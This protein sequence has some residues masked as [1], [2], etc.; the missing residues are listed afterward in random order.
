MWD[1][2]MGAKSA[3]TPTCKISS[4]KKKKKEKKKRKSRNMEIDSYSKPYCQATCWY[5]QHALWKGKNQQQA[6][7]WT[8]SF[9]IYVFSNFIFLSYLYGASAQQA[10]SPD[11]ILPASLW[12]PSGRI[13]LHLPL[14]LQPALLQLSVSN[15]KQGDGS[16][17]FK[18]R[19]LLWS[20]KQQKY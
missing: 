3:Q 16:C 18:E 12:L 14:K 8:I 20:P 15:M 19:S 10:P 9:T 1:N 11:G 5:A 2:L 6:I 13:A 4:Y 17:S 7:Q